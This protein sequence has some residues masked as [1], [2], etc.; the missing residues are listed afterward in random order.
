[1]ILF[2][3]IP[4]FICIFFFSLIVRSQNKDK[5]L[6]IGNSLTYYNNMPHM[7]EKVCE[8]F[9]LNLT[10]EQSTYS[11]VSL[12]THTSIFWYK[13]KGIDV[14]T[15]KKYKELQDKFKVNSSKTIYPTTIE[16][17]VNNNFKYIFIQE[18][19]NYILNTFLRNNYTLPALK[20][21][22]SIKK[23]GTKIFL[24]QGYT[25]INYG[26]RCLKFTVCQQKKCVDEF[27]CSPDF[28]SFEEMNDT[29]INLY[30]SISQK[31]ACEISPISQVFEQ[32]RKNQ[33][34]LKLY[35]K[36]NHPTKQ[37]SFIIAC[38]YFASIS[39]TKNFDKLTYNPHLKNFKKI[40]AELT[41]FFQ[42]YDF[43]N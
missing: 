3:H 17:I 6:F 13:K 43:N 31:I 25:G 4:L 41:L 2:K 5:V 26:K 42:N 14:E 35:K 7:F 19:Q 27:Y 38:V 28:K 23:E 37:A 15:L 8:N 22:D 30:N 9:N 29:I 20:Q 10:K 36:G 1:M 24:F 11:G 18:Q 16:K 39:K 33:P 12:K 32:F 34:K 21:F 40:K